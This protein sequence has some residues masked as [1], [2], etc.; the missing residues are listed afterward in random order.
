[1][2][3]YVHKNSKYGHHVAIPDSD[4][5][6]YFSRAARDKG[7]VDEILLHLSGGKEENVAAMT[8]YLSKYLIERYEDEAFFSASQCGLPIS[9]SVNP[10]SVSD[11][12][13][14]ANIMLTILRI[15]CNYI[16]KCIWEACYFT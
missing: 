6:E 3:N 13:D 4:T 16:K 1:M 8:Q 15:I 9:T 10:E 2:L 7:W 11:M 14:D 5:Q 12:V